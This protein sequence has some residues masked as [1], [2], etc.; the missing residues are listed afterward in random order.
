MHDLIAFGFCGSRV[1]LVVSALCAIALAYFSLGF[2]RDYTVLLA[3]LMAY[4]VSTIV[5]IAVNLM[6]SS[7]FDF[8]QI[9]QKVINYDP[10]KPA[11][12]G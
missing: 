8:S 3:S 10:A 5:C 1:G 7:K 6:S 12:Q 4:G 2:L 9:D 11:T